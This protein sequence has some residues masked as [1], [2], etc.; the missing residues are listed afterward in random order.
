MNT[1]G[2]TPQIRDASGNICNALCES[3]K[4]FA[5]E[6]ASA[7]TK[8]PEG[9]IQFPLEPRIPYTLENIHFTPEIVVEQ[10]RI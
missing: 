5:P 10:L 9:D 8:E 1:K 4:I 6:F 3:A 7:F 2:T